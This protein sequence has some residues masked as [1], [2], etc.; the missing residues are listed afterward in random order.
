MPFTHKANA[1]GS[2]ALQTGGVDRILLGNDGK[3]KLTQTQT[4]ADGIAQYGQITIVQT[5]FASYTAISAVT[6]VIPIDGTV[7]QNTEGVQILSLTITPKKSTNKIRLR[8]QGNLSAHTAGASVIAAVF[9]SNSPNALQATRYAIPSTDQMLPII[10]ECEDSPGA[11]TPVTYTVRVGISAGTSYP[12]SNG[13]GSA[14]FGTGG[15]GKA[16]TLILEEIQQ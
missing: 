3:V 13:S 7:P 9:S 8:F 4:D 2:A 16:C 10:L 1:D 6:A 15:G 12:N 5:L 14:E 11:I